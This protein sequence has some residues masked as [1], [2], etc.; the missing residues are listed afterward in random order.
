M[1]FVRLKKKREKK[2]YISIIVWLKYFFVVYS[3][4][5]AQDKFL[6]SQT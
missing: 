1:T 6:T 3:P 2:K 5:I 4:E